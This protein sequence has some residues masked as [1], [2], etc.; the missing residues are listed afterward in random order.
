VHEIAIAILWELDEGVGIVLYD[1]GL[2]LMCFVLFV[3]G[4]EHC[5]YVWIWALR[6][7]NSEYHPSP[8]PSPNLTNFY[9]LA[10]IEFTS[11]MTI[12]RLW[13]CL[14]QQAIVFNETVSQ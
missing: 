10:R 14:M 13:K 3:G 9:L 1:E 6:N 12:S 8:H 5:S 7:V 4:W 11:Q 2:L